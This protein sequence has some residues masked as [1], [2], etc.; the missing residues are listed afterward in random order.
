MRG[1]RSRL[2]FAKGAGEDWIRPAGSSGFLDKLR[3]SQQEVF[4]SIDLV[5]LL[6]AGVVAR[7]N[8][9]RQVSAQD[10]GLFCLSPCL[11]PFKNPE[12][13]FAQYGK[14]KFTYSLLTKEITGKYNIKTSEYHDF[15]SGNIIFVY[16]GP[17]RLQKLMKQKQFVFPASDSYDPYLEDCLALLV[18]GFA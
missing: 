8:E 11:V 15:I 4:Q 14:L 17:N 2:C 18:W 12:N 3:L 1:G 13:S 6:R 7:G 9:A 5:S 16:L 10:Q